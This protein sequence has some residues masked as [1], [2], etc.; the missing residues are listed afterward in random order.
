MLYLFSRLGFIKISEKQIKELINLLQK[1]NQKIGLE[2]PLKNNQAKKTAQKMQRKIPILVG[3]EFLSGN[4]HILRNQVCE[5]CKTY[6]DF[7]LLPD[8]NHFAMEGLQY[9]S[10]NKKNLLFFFVESDLYKQRITQ[11]CNLSKK[12][13][14]KNNIEIISYKPSSDSKF[15]QSFELLH[16]GTWLTYYLGI[17]NNVDPAVVPYVDWFKKEL[18]KLPFKKN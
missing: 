5:T 12:I 8:L 15:L 6:S 17:L 9:P 7:L 1:N 4:M 3:A 13:V 2:V 14:Q 11:R 16:Y 10:S 18:A